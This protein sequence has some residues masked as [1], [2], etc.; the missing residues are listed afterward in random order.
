[1]MSTTS[2]TRLR[3]SY[4]AAIWVAFQL[5]LA[6]AALLCCAT[7]DAQT[8]LEN[9][10][11]EVYYISDGDDATDTIGGTLA[12]GSRTYRV[13]IDLDTSCALRAVYGDA[14]HPLDISSTAVFFNHLDRGHAYG[15]EINNGWLDQGTVALDSWLSLGAASNQKLGILKSEDPDGSVVGGANND[16]GSAEISAGLLSNADAGAGIPL[17]TQDGLAPPSGG[18]AI[19]PNF[20]LSGDDPFSVFG[21]MSVAT[22]FVSDSMRIA[23][24][25]PGV[26][27]PTAENKILIA[28]LTTTGDLAFHLNIE[29]E[30][31]DGTLIKYVSSDSVLMP[32]ETASGLL[33]YPPV[34]GC[35]D[36]NFLEFDP[37]A[38]CDDGSCATA[39]IFG[40]LDTLAC[41]FDPSANFNVDEL[42]CYGPLDC[43]GLDVT[44]VCPDLG[45]QEEAIDELLE[46]YPNP[47]SEG[48]N[49]RVPGREMVPMS[50]TLRDPVGRIVRSVRAKGAIQ[51]DVTDLAVGVYLLQ[52][53]LEGHTLTRRIVKD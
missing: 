1:M 18:V 10:S 45:T 42:C 32:D 41:N 2:G 4:A 35:T 48:L 13:F 31:S 33:V 37:N 15:H 51:L 22:A 20:N 14:N 30:T 19:P 23:C 25:T 36:P 40:C 6:I 50:V 29:V 11:V 21:D 38:G 26:I 9:V 39:I 5:T 53:E 7:A 16:G 47:A 12:E 43:N 24:T 28:Q 52:V 46:V 34:C 27:G 3:A 49:V 44:I 8:H 17:T